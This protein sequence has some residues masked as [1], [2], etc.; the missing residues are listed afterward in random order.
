MQAANVVVRTWVG[1]GALLLV[2]V[3]ARLGLAEEEFPGA[4][5]EAAQM[6]CVPTC[7]MCHTSNP[8]KA[9]TWPGRKLSVDLLATGKFRLKA[10][11]TAGVKA[12]YAEYAASHAAEAEQI[13]KGIQPETGQ[14]VC[15]PTYGCGARMAAANPSD[16][17]SMWAAALTAAL[18]GVVW[19][20][21]RR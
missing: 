21:R 12:A 4:L 19:A 1:I 11:D 3:H 18:L 15:S 5:A 13:K 16:D 20:R 10:G 8:G 6:D 17:A 7:L 2:L 9:D 14:D